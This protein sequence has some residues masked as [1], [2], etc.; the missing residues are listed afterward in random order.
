MLITKYNQHHITVWMVTVNRCPLK[1]HPLT[2]TW[3]SKTRQ[4]KYNSRIITKTTTIMATTL[5]TSLTLATMPEPQKIKSNKTT[6]SI[7]ITHNTDIL[8][9][10]N[11]ITQVTTCY[12]SRTSSAWAKMPRIPRPTDHLCPKKIS[13]IYWVSM[14][15]KSK[16]KPSLLRPKGSLTQNHTPTSQKDFHT[17]NNKITCMVNSRPICHAWIISHQTNK[18]PPTTTWTIKLHN[19]KSLTLVPSATCQMPKPST[20]NPLFTS[21]LT[22]QTR[23]RT[24]NSNT[25]WRKW[26][27]SK[28]SRALTTSK[29]SD[30]NTKYSDR[31][32]INLVNNSEVSSSSTEKRKE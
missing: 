11:N 29:R 26:T 9:I 24:C 8:W 3:C 16:H 12:H 20:N 1:C 10:L 18:P 2:W 28:P 13:V 22:T 32:T 7:S 23:A 30:S 19:N 21:K 31:I 14:I 25:F 15:S 27:G 6:T 17:F 5:M 4:M